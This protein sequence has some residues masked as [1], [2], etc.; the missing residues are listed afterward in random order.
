MTKDLLS[1]VVA[2][3]AELHQ[4]LSTQ[5]PV[6][7]HLS[8]D[9]RRIAAG[10]VFVACPGVAGDGRDHVAA[11]LAA[12]AGAVLFEA[13]EASS[14]L[15][16]S[17]AMAGV[18]GLAVSGLRTY[19][20]ALA[21][22]WYGRAS[23]QLTVVAV[24]GTNG[25]TS[26]V[27]WVAQALQSQGQP[28]GVIGT[29]GVRW[30]NGSLQDTGLT[31]PDVI[32]LH[33]ALAA[34]RDAGAVA[35]ALEASSIGIDQ[36]RL[37]G[38]NVTV[39]AFTN[40]TRDHLDW[41]G[42]MEA[43]EAAKARL[44]AWPGLQAAVVNRD[45]P[46]GARLLAAA[47]SAPWLSYAIDD[48][49]ADVQATQVVDTA[50]GM[51]FTLRVRALPDDAAPG[52]LPVASALPGRH[53]VSNLL[54]VAGV[55]REL[56]WQPA[57]IAQALG[58]LTPVQGRLEAVPLP[59]G[60][61]GPLVLVDYAHT[62]DALVRALASLAPLA[63][64]RG[65]RIHCL[66]GCG[67]DRDPGKR[68][69]M[70]R[71]ALAGA[72]RI[73]ITS[74]NPRSEDPRA[75][76]D[77]IAAG[78]PAEALAGDTVRCEPDRA[79][80]I[81]DTLLAADA[82]DVVLVAGKGHENYQE[83]QGQ[84]LTFADTHWARLGL[85]LLQVT[86]V[87][88]DTRAL[89]TGELFVAL[90]GDQFDGHNFLVQ[91]RDAGAVAAVVAHP[92]AEV[93]GIEQLVLGD[94]RQALARMAAAWRARHTLPLIAVAGSNGKTTTKEMIAAIL[95][96]WLGEGHA[97]ASRASFNNDIGLPLSLLRLRPEHRCAVLEIGTNH[98]GEIAPLAA[99]AAP[100]IALITNAQRDHQEFLLTVEDG[101]R[102]NGALLLALPA[103][104]VVVYPADDA[105]APIWTDMAG[106]RPRVGFGTGPQA[107]FYA[108]D[109]A[110][111][112]TGSQFMLH[113]P[114][115]AVTI[116]LTVPG[117]HNVRNALA[118]AASVVAAG[119]PL[120]AVAEGLGRFS[121]V[122]GRLLTHTHPDGR[123]LIDDSYNAN[124]DSVR[125]A[126][127]VLA[128]FEGARA[129]VLGDMG[130][131]GT[132]GPAMHRE[133]GAYARERGIAHLVGIGEAAK[134]AVAAF[135]EG[136]VH[137][138]SVDDI[139]QHIGTVQPAVTL[140]KGSLFMAMGRV[141]T[142]LIAAEKQQT[143]REGIHAA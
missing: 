80:A 39:A 29:L 91:A 4:W 101:A 48:A 61:A 60:V 18:P 58:Q 43:Y 67:G 110:V 98:V 141:V 50:D 13:E 21:H 115:G 9:S 135:G 20:G 3:A 100:T 42:T 59:E 112:G 124:A 118:A 99:I 111:Q 73:V 87:N 26:C 19:V 27:H 125:A 72:H 56:G 57:V 106:E 32:T 132:D 121:A 120:S 93:E 142:A 103:D 94:T 65:G 17:L 126:I 119:C 62:P 90:S 92:V 131:A 83:I 1:A 46:A 33:R 138:A 54:L 55:L 30:P 116:T 97:L 68:P 74:D 78:L 88:T 37:D 140:V 122:K 77:D 107:A 44:F 134:L 96:A 28:C 143:C 108:T 114:Q 89:K 130:E 71:A 40:L 104:G 85:Q 35:V 14:G 75:I 66:F 12:G 76:L 47:G 25:K 45:D 105:C 137:V 38:L 2:R 8:M 24:T 22:A 129:L 53:N 102:E 23:E 64:A 49:A 5:V 86:G 127:D 133:V 139:V 16:A 31:S 70:G 63:A 15:A 52:A 10:D 109:V 79:R 84:R 7:V 51:R 136:G 11:A 69:E 6:T 123:L 81:L 113:A 128:G 117:A 34:L 41:H 95:T 82:R 36:G